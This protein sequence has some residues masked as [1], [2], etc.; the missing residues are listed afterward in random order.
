MSHLRS[1]GF[2]TYGEPP[3]KG[4]PRSDL[5]RWLRGLYLKPLPILLVIC[6]LAA[7]ALASGAST[8]ILVPLGVSA[9]IWVQGIVSLS[10]RIRRE[11]R[12]EA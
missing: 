3:P 11:E 10:I 6:V 2:K 7:L 8:W 12:R 9:A 4:A 5:L 1:L